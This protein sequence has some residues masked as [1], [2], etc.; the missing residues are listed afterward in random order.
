MHDQHIAARQIG[1]KIFGAP[2]KRYHGL[3]AQA[4]GKAGRKRETQIGPAQFHRHQA[5]ADHGRRQ[6]PPDRLHFR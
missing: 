5:R 6:A 1:Q 2:A 3:A 4:L